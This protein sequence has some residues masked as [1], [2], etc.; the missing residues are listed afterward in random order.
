MKG[1]FWAAGHPSLSFSCSPCQMHSSSSST[2]KS[3][4][5]PQSGKGSHGYKGRKE[6]GSCRGVKR[7]GRRNMV[8]F[9]KCTRLQRR[10]RPKTCPSL[11]KFTQWHPTFCDAMDCSSPDSS[12][13]GTF[14]A[15]ILEWFA[16]SYSN[17]LLSRHQ[18]HNNHY[19]VLSQG[20]FV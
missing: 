13:R 11:L 20:C 4:E 19:Y 5:D 1:L 12:V 18:T 16:I 3:R 8:D 17:A 10:S 7:G 9:T 14:Q 15:R 6:G 2:C